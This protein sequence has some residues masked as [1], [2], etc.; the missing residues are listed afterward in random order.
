M[1]HATVVSNEPAWLDGV[2]SVLK[3]CGW[4]FDITDPIRPTPTR[5]GSVLVAHREEL[6]QD[7]VERYT[8]TDCPMLLVS[9]PKELETILFLG[10]ADGH[11][12]RPDPCDGHIVARFWGVRGS[13]PTPGP[14][15]LRYGGNTS[16][17]EIR[18][19][20]EIIIIDAGTGIRNL[21]DSLMTEAHGGNLSLTILLT[22]THWDH[23]QGFPFFRPAYGVGN[24]IRI[25]ERE[26]PGVPAERLLETQMSSPYF[27]IAMR[28]MAG[29]I[30][31]LTFLTEPFQIGKVKVTAFPVNHPGNCVG[32]KVECG[33]Y[34]ICHISDNELDPSSSAAHLKNVTGESFDAFRNR[35]IE[36][37]R[38]CDLLI[39][40]SQYCDEEMSVRRYWGHSSISQTV[41]LAID[42]GVKHL[43]LTHHD[44]T[45]ND[46]WVDSALHTAREI[47]QQAG[48]TQLIVDA[49]KEGSAITVG[50]HRP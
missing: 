36:T 6:S 18:A 3:R 7:Q 42:A 35:L 11:I 44:P 38:G 10:S 47:A 49:A 34:S 26:I 48:A 12:F 41:H 14:S 22:H 5:M 37:I 25:Y 45:H 23:I 24:R 40:D 27:P 29:D 43:L 17:L 4:G 30:E 9:N 13:I 20:G 15:T 39:H 8:M 50:Q 31:T 19:E 46:V 32:F 1:K 2:C 21:G 28:D 16:C 33:G